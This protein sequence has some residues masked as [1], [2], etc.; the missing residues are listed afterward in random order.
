VSDGDARPLCA[1]AC[2][3]ALAAGQRAL[4]ERGGG[5]APIMVVLGY[6]KLWAPK[7]RRK[8]GKKRGRTKERKERSFVL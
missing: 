3:E 8:K 6:F 1:P 4:C 2:W 5:G 7:R